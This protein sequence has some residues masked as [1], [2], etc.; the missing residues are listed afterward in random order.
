MT[1]Q[2]VLLTTIFGSLAAPGFAETFPYT[3]TVATSNATARS[4][5]SYG[6]YATERLPKYSQVTVHQAGPAG[7]VAIRPL[8]E[9]FDWLPASSVKRT[10]GSAAGEIVALDTPCWIGSNVKKVEKHESQLKL[11]KGDKV[12]VL[13]EIGDGQAWLKIAPPAGEFRWVQEKHLSRKSPEQLKHDDEAERVAREDRYRQ[14]NA[15]DPPGPLARALHT[16]PVQQA[17]GSAVGSGVEQA[18]LLRR[19]RA[20]ILRPRENGRRDVVNKPGDDAELPK[21]DIEVGAPA[22]EA[23]PADTKPPAATPEKTFLVERDGASLDPKPSPALPVATPRA[24]PMPEVRVPDPTPID[25]AEFEQLLTRLDVDLMNMVAADSSQWQ[26]KPLRERAEALVNDGPS[27]VERGRARLLLERIAEFEATLPA[28]HN[29]PPAVATA[30]PREAPAKPQ[31][32]TQYDGV[33]YLMPVIT[34]RPGTPPYQLVDQNGRTLQFVSPAPGVNLSRY[35]KK[36]VGVYGQRGYLESLKKQHI[37][38]QAVVD[39]DRHR[40]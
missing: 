28:D 6:H 20:P 31:L 3:A 30:T 11:R 37:T 35:V 40:R 34:A 22:Q 14:Q 19:G 18:Q 10:P 15:V 29:E 4:G 9:A 2:L 26:L 1:R 38:A 5:P 13:A 32:E 24:E 12:H 17:G 36:Q 27:P 33:G 16:E 8:P 21:L 39:L 23:K 25:S 7:W